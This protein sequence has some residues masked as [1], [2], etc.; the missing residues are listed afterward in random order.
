MSITQY[1]GAAMIAMSGKGCVGIA[2]DRRLGIRNM[3]KACDFKKVFQ[4]N[5]KIMVGFSGLAT[6]LQ[7]LE[8][9]LR[10]RTNMYKLREDREIS[11]DAFGNLVASMQYEKRFGYYFV[12]PVIAGLKADN[13]PYLMSSDIIGA[14]CFKDDF[15][16]A[17]DTA[18]TLFGMCESV[19]RP[20][21]VPEELFEVLSQCLLSGVDRDCLAGW[22]ATVYIMTPEGV[23]E[24][25]L[26]GRMD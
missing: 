20:D 16:V 9:R 24:T 10:M 3:T 8:Q 26:K 2:V 22:G 19:Y 14:Q 5:D 4:V 1:N 17:G 18:E 13:T 21:L 7:T 23:Q 12:E 11:V 25:N 6:D 15:V